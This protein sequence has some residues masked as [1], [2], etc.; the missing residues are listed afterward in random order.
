MSHAAGTIRIAV[1]Q[2]AYGDDESVQAR[3][4]RVSGWVREQA[5]ADLVVLPELWPMGGFDYRAWAEKA[6][7][8][9]GPVMQALSQ[10]A[11][12]IGAFVHAGSIVERPADGDVGPEGKGLWNTSMVFGPDGRR[13]ARYRKIHRFGFA[14]GEPE[15]MEAGEESVSVQLPG[16]LP[17][18]LST[19]Y[20]LR[21]PELYRHQIDRGAQVFVIPAAWPMARVEHWR[22]LLRARALENQ[23]LVIACNTAGTHAGSQMGGH[24]AVVA[25]TGEVLAEAGEDQEVL[26]VDVPTD[27]VRDARADFPV[28]ADRRWG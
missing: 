3:T 4:E 2:L 27:L 1:L 9:D 23:A 18:A 14:G 19:C 10:A 25:P 17:A 11:A 6:Q 20:D 13:V 5:G 16:E 22:L 26:S 8:I 15:L 28:L 24:S 21:F 7:A 12:D